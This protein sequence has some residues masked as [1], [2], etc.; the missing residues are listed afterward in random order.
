MILSA[1]TLFQ[2]PDSTEPT[3]D[4]IQDPENT[5]VNTQSNELETVEMPDDLLL[6]IGLIDN[7]VAIVDGLNITTIDDATLRGVENNYVYYQS[8]TQLRRAAVDNINNVEL[9][10][11]NYSGGTSDRILDK[12]VGTNYYWF[13]GNKYGTLSNPIAFR[14]DL[15]DYNNFG[16]YNDRYYYTEAEHNYS[17]GE[18][19]VNLYTYSLPSLEIKQVDNILRDPYGNYSMDA[20]FN[21]FILYSCGNNVFYFDIYDFT[22]ETLKTNIY[23]VPDMI[24]LAELNGGLGCEVFNEY[25]IYYIEYLDGSKTVYYSVVFNSIDR[26]FRLSDQ[27]ITFDFLVYFD[28][29]HII[30]GDYMYFSKENFI[31]KMDMSAFVTNFTVSLEKI[32]TEFP[33]FDF[34]KYN[35]YLFVLGYNNQKNNLYYFNTEQNKLKLCSELPVSTGYYIIFN[36]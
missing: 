15:P 17:T 9:V 24:G 31:Y 23:Q 14:D 25:V 36:K 4:V 6:A 13:G 28:L 10:Q 29:P 22:T 27:L 34:Q 1:C 11:K 19:S 7:K 8:G 20:V 2:K 30:I 5:A 32:N 26:T 12:M 33:V 21:D 16:Y 3:N 18:S 35:N